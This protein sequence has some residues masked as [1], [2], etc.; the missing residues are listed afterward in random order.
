MK[1][2]GN[3]KQGDFLYI[4]GGGQTYAVPISTLWKGGYRC[5]EREGVEGVHDA[6]GG[7]GLR[8]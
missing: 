4:K 7:I 6:I 3:R 2:Q 5:G 1:G 8:G